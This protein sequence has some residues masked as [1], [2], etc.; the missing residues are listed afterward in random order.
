MYMIRKGRESDI[1]E[2]VGIYELIHTNE[3]KVKV[4]TGWVRGI[5]PTGDDARDMLAKDELFVLED[6]G[7]VV[8]SAR[9]NKT[10]VDVYSRVNWQYDAPDSEVMVLHT[11]AVDPLAAGKG[12]GTAFVRF[13][14]KY[15]LANGCHYLRIDT[16]A[17]NTPA[18]RLYAKLGYSEVGVVRCD[19][20][21]IRSIDLVCLEKKL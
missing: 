19:F 20:N 16:N 4:S 11:L 21:N 8:A 12:Y 14:E 18:R 1:P 2:I 10:Q 3:E 7:R 9:I 15:A 6:G 5:Y 17:L 13:Y